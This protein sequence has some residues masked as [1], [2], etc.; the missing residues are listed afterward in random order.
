MVNKECMNNSIN[1]VLL[2]LKK[3]HFLLACAIISD[4]VTSFSVLRGM[5][6]FIE[7]KTP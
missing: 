2:T 1:C 7:V 4:S 3:E 6:P 5:N